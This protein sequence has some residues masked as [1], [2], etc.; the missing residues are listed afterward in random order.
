MSGE[1]FP[2]CPRCRT[3]M[4]LAFLDVVSGP[5]DRPSSVSVFACNGCG[6]LAAFELPVVEQ[7]DER[8]AALS[9]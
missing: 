6:R 1:L 9:G 5:D 8:A 3:S 2:I 7:R 4:H